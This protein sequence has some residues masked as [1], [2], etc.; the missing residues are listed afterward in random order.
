MRLLLPL[1]ACF[2]TQSDRD[3]ASDRDNDGF[4]A[5]ELGGTD[6]DDSS[7]LVYPGAPESCLDDIDSD[8]DGMNCP[9]RAARDSALWASKVLFSNGAFADFDGDGVPEL[10]LSEPDAED[11]RGLVYRLDLPL[12]QDGVPEAQAR[13]SVRGE[14]EQQLWAWP[15]GDTDG[16]GDPDVALSTRY[17]PGVVYV[18]DSVAQRSDGTERFQ[19]RWLVNSSDSDGSATTVNGQRLYFGQAKT[20]GD[21]DGDG[22]DDTVLAAPTA[23]LSDVDIGVVYLLSGAPEGDTPSSQNN[24]AA[25]RGPNEGAYLGAILGS[26]LDL[27]GDGQMEALVG[28]TGWTPNGGGGQNQIGILY[29]LSVDSETVG[30]APVAFKGR[31]ANAKISGGDALGDLNGDG[32]EDLGVFL[33]SGSGHVLIFLGPLEGEYFPENADIRLLG[34]VGDEVTSGFGEGLLGRMDLNEDGLGDLMVSATGEGSGDDLARSVGATY[35]YYGPLTGVQSP[36]HAA[37]RWEGA[38]E[39]GAQR[40]DLVGDLDQDGALELLLLAPAD[41]LGANEVDGAVRV[42]WALDTLAPR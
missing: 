33:S 42:D 5:Q 9:A 23:D 12:E 16:D 19:D 36:G 4:V 32:H 25:W 37:A 28:A 27:D 34:D 21:V 13:G 11:D 20:I 15:I 3:A 1:L 18:V 7:A 31:T 17:G 26:S 30:D 22:F 24:L 38:V 10:L 14:L 8:C 2:V 39:D 35:L 40:A 29:G 6:C 41:G